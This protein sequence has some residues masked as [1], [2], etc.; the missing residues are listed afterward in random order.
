MN[1]PDEMDVKAMCAWM[2]RGLEPDKQA[3]CWKK[4]KERMDKVGPIPRHIFDEKSYKDRL[5][6]INGALLAIKLTD[7]GEYFTLR[8]GKLWYSED[9]SHK[10][11]KVVREITKKGAELFLNA[12]ISADIGFRIADRLEKK[13]GAKGSFVANIGIAWCSCFPSSGTIRFVR[14]H[15]WGVCHCIIKGTQ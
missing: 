1:C 7:V 12:T 6:A 2:E 14:I 11:V 10:L 8:G 15:L 4:V 13:M 3:E 9:P 5:A